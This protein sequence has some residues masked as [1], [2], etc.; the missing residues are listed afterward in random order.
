MKTIDAVSNEG[1][2]V[3]CFAS[4]SVGFIKILGLYMHFREYFGRGIGH[5]TKK[6]IILWDD[7][8]PGIGL[9]TTS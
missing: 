1:W 4:Q 5:E 3:S 9:V 8:E 7:L 2:L 6:S